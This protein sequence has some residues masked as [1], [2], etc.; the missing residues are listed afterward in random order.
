MKQGRGGKVRSLDENGRALDG[1]PIK[2]GDVFGTLSGGTT[3]PYPASKREMAAN[4]WLIENAVAEAT[5]R[6]DSL[7]ATVFGAERRGQK[8]ALPPASVSSMLLYLFAWQPEVVPSMTRR[9]GSPLS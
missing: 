4:D 2:A 7:N 9:M 5:Q 6:G 1:Q 3:T 8:S